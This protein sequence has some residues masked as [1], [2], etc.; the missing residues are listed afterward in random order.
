VR[1]ELAALEL[2]RLSWQRI[3]DAG[4]QVW[5][6]FAEHDLLTYASAMSFQ[7]LY[8]V[9]PLLMLALGVLGLL[10]GEWIYTKH[11]ATTLHHHLSKD[12]YALVDKT[13]R[14]VLSRE[15]MYWATGGLLVTVW[16]VSAALRALMVPLNRIYGSRET[17]PTW[18]RL[19]TSL[20]V[21][22]VVIVLV[23]GAVAAGLLTRLVSPRGFGLAALL[24]VARW[25][26]AI[27]LLLL[28]IGVIVRFVPAAKPPVRWVS[29]GAVLSA[30]C[31]IGATLLFVLYVSLVSYTSLY[32]FLSSVVLLLVYL[33][34]SAIGF[35][36]G[37]VVDALLRE[38]VD[39][40]D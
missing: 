38:D 13:A 31:W 3:R 5:Q 24:L 12:A 11:V 35:L 23:Y 6:P 34:L 15:R 19:T 8:A 9:I 7:I 39:E 27:L 17:R 40:R 21:A 18:R 14:H 37:N 10:G 26:T 33:H 32:G 36:L 28:A 25:A 2:R 29:L 4:V 16:G 30:L 20:W 1:A 22:V